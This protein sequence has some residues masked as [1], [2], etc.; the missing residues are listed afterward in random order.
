MFLP[1]SRGRFWRRCRPRSPIRVGSTVSSSISP[2]WCVTANH[3]PQTSVSESYSLFAERSRSYSRHV[4]LLMRRSCTGSLVVIHLLVNRHTC[5]RHIWRQH[6]ERTKQGNVSS[7]QTPLRPPVAQKPLGYHF[8]PT[9]SQKMKSFHL[10]GNKDGVSVMLDNPEYC[11][12][13]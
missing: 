3:Q 11:L 8:T 4:S 5:L 10:R 13:T 9:R 2:Q 7:S 12:R 1:H 6:G